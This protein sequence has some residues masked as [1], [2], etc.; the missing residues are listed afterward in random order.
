M[1]SYSAPAESRV[2]LGRMSSELV[3]VGRFELPASSSR[4]KRAAKLRYTPPARNLSGAARD[5]DSL[6]ERR[7]RSGTPADSARSGERRGHLTGSRGT[8]VSKVA[9]GR[10]ANLTGAQGDVPSPA[11][12]CSQAWPPSG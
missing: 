2:H 6:A 9:S 5:F 11:E 8:S 10:Q 1:F 3:G 7:T 12:T 4:T